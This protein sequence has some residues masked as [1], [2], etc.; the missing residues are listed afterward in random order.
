MRFDHLQ[1]LVNWLMILGIL[2]KNDVSSK[3]A[4]HQKKK[5]LR[6]GDRRDALGAGVLR[7]RLQARRH[8]TC[9][10]GYRHGHG[11]LPMMALSL[12]LSLSPC[13]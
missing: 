1:R 10:G 3:F 11:W 9:V 7:D 13:V 8:G 6:G 2:C 4:V 12:S 5:G